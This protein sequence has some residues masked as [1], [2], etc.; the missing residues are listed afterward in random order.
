MLTDY[1]ACSLWWAT[2]RNLKKLTVFPPQIGGIKM[3]NNKYMN[4]LATSLVAFTIN[5]CVSTQPNNEQK[6]NPVVTTEYDTDGNRVSD[7]LE[8]LMS[9][10]NYPIY[11]FEYNPNSS[12]EE[13]EL[14]D[15]LIKFDRQVNK[16]D[17]L[18]IKL[19]K[20]EYSS[21]RINNTVLRAGLPKSK[22]AEY[23]QI[24]GVVLI[25]ENYS[26]QQN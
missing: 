11:P 7:R 3:L 19:F 16:D 2:Y 8:T 12:N 25:E 23:A 26:I 1:Q 18:M 5:G 24:N 6:L 22:L 9:E 14:V 10:E 13:Q 20:G 21:T 15:V 17:K 4:F